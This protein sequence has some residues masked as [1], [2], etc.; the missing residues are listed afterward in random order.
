MWIMFDSSV[1]DWCIIGKKKTFKEVVKNTVCNRYKWLLTMSLVVLQ[2]V[3]IFVCMWRLFGRCY[4]RLFTLI[5]VFFPSGPLSHLPSS[6]CLDLGLIFY[7]FF[8]L[9]ASSFLILFLLF[10]SCDDTLWGIYYVHKAA[11]S[12]FTHSMKLYE[13]FYS[14]FFIWPFHRRVHL[15]WLLVTHSVD[16]SLP[17]SRITKSW[18][19]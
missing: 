2:N 15:C 16:P 5:G 18:Q 1:C 8:S 9:F 13:T 14:I 7:L 4:G 3:N 6:V 10:T 12:N 17:V 11:E 19:P